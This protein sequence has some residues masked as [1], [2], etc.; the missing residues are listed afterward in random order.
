MLYEYRGQHRCVLHAGCFL[1]NA[2]PKPDLAVD[3]DIHIL[4]GGSEFYLG[5]WKTKCY[6]RTK[7]R[8]QGGLHVS[9]CFVDVELEVVSS[10]MGD[11]PMK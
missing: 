1:L 5:D 2:S 6:F 10:V 9:Q 7:T 4:G 11:G 8:Q 3:L